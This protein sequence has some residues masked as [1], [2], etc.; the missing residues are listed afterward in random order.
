[1]AKHM[2]W[3]NYVEELQFIFNVLVF[4]FPQTLPI[5][6]IDLCCRQAFISWNQED[7]PFSFI[8][9]LWYSPVMHFWLLHYLLPN[10]TRAFVQITANYVLCKCSYLHTGSPK[11]YIVFINCI[12]ITLDITKKKKWMFPIVFQRPL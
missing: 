3:K 4:F 9:L 8:I 6:I 10:C 12:S 11:Y 2:L 7:S 5:N 1:M